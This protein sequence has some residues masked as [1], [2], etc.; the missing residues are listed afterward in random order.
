MI[1]SWEELGEVLSEF[2]SRLG[3]LELSDNGALVH[4][5]E[6]R[7]KELEKTI[8]ALKIP[9]WNRKQW[10]TVEQLQS[11]VRGWRQKHAELLLALDKRKEADNSKYV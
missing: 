11:E 5:L 8:E 4:S 7:I 10:D 6:E 2:E 3:V 1:K 9:E